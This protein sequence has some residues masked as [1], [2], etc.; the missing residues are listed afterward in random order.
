[1]CVVRGDRVEQGWKP[2][3]LPISIEA[4]S[5]LSV[6]PCCTEHYQNSGSR[7]SKV[8]ITQIGYCLGV[9]GFLWDVSI[10]PPY[11]SGR[12][13][14]SRPAETVLAQNHGC[15][16]MIIDCFPSSL[17]LVRLHVPHSRRGLN[18]WPC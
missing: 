2:S 5:E 4:I 9:A 14:L 8:Y 3:S 16:C 6:G 18:F 7:L 12:R 15:A 17:L 10:K 11:G 13:D 1:M